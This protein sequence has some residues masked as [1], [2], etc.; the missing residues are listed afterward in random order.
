VALHIDRFE[1]RIA[2][3]D[4]HHRNVDGGKNIDIHQAEAERAENQHQ[5]S[6]NSNG[7]G[8][9]KRLIRRREGDGMH[10]EQS[11]P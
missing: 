7:K 8:A 9:A 2:P 10:M 1:T 6:H 11:R 5:E 4:H 3:Y